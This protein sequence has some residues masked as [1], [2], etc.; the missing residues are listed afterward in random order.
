MVNILSPL[1]L[2][3]PKN[4]ISEVSSTKSKFNYLI[5][6]VLILSVEFW[7]LFIAKD[8][9][10]FNIAWFEL[11]AKTEK[12]ILKWYSL[13]ERKIY[14]NRFLKEEYD[15]G[16]IDQDSRLLKKLNEQKRILSI[17]KTN[18]VSKKTKKI[19]KLKV[20]K[21]V[22][23]EPETVAK[24]TP[25]KPV[26]K[27]KATRRKNLGAIPQ[28]KKFIPR[29]TKTAIKAPV[30]ETPFVKTKQVYKTQDKE[31]IQKTPQKEDLVVDFPQDPVAQDQ[32]NNSKDFNIK[33]P[34]FAKENNQTEVWIKT[35]DWAPA[36]DLKHTLLTNNRKA[37]TQVRLEK[38][39]EITK[40]WGTQWFK[41][42]DWVF[43]VSINLMKKLEALNFDGVSWSKDT[44]LTQ[45]QLW[46]EYEHW[47]DDESL[48]YQFKAAFVYSQVD[49]NKLWKVWDIFQSWVDVWD[50]NGGFSWGTNLKALMEFTM[51]LT[52]NF[53]LDIR[54]WLE[55]YK[56]NSLYGV[57]WDSKL[58]PTFGETLRWKPTR[59]TNLELIWDHSDRV[60]SYQLNYTHNV[61]SNAFEIG[62]WVSKTDY[63]NSVW[64][65]DS[66][67]PHVFAR[68]KCTY[69]KFLDIFTKWCWNLKN[70]LFNTHANKK[71]SFSDGDYVNW[72]DW[73]NFEAW[74][75]VTQRVLDADQLL[76]VTQ[77]KDL[78]CWPALTYSNDIPCTWTTVGSAVWYT[79]YINDG[80][81]TTSVNTTSS[82]HTFSGLSDGSYSIQVEAFNTNG[83][84][85]MSDSYSVVK[86]TVI[87]TS[88]TFDGG[89]GYLYPDTKDK[90]FDKVITKF[91]NKL[92][93][94]T[95]SNVSVS[96]GW[97]YESYNLDAVTW[98]VTFT[99]LYMPNAS[100]I[101]MTITGTNSAGKP[102]TVSFT[103]GLPN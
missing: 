97:S 37:V 49:K 83:T 2:K 7:S 45:K 82:S 101:T 27:V 57:S 19:V 93:W 30:L 32:I 43:T 6:G 75:T 92:I 89:P 59:Y 102:F 20:E 86:N 58:S 100:P 44:T 40:I 95:V 78:S 72:M 12:D 87:P 34:I 90:T 73:Y 13:E 16:S 23:F 46:A 36:L 47:F 28:K 11:W 96:S 64:I 98:E 3:K 53:R 70:K 50:I 56:N 94:W 31:P 24:K 18:S 74:E 66:V 55:Q 29:K 62:A 1:S 21:K 17:S 85:V 8:A 71:L 38:G 14:S 69:D 42:K 48:L 99:N 39:T 88:F 22:A 68:M 103:F 77:V 67:S 35:I 41:V 15:G 10:A 91:D 4:A 26:K 63:S 81:T 54:T 33:L 76:L 84:S 61:F 65:K 80:T 5:M 25:V 9:Q 52:D 51:K 79:I 60:N